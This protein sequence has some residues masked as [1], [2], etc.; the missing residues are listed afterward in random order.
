MIRFS[1]PAGNQKKARKEIAIAI[2]GLLLLV[3]WRVPPIAVVLFTLI[4]SV[5]TGLV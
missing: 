3:R 4:C 5:A 2:A 1:A